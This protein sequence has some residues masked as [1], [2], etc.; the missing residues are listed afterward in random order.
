MN[1][2]GVPSSLPD[3]LLKLIWIHWARHMGHPVCYS[4]MKHTK[5]L[6]INKLKRLY[7]IYYIYKHQ[8]MT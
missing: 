2:Q 6:N 5:R 4:Y 3:E 1:V 7:F 8:N